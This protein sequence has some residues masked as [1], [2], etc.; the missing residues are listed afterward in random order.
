MQKKKS[1]INFAVLAIN[2]TSLEILYV[3][4]KAMNYIYWHAAL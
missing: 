3:D 2:E 4:M 1:E